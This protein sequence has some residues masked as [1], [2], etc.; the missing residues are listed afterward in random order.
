M[1][2]KREPV[3]G[4]GSQSNATDRFAKHQVYLDEEFEAPHPRTEFMK[5]ASRTVLAENKSPDIPFRYSINPYRGCEHGCIYCYARPSH[6]YLGFSAGLDF[7]TKILVK[8]EAPERLAEQFMAARWTPE[9]IMLSGNT[10]CYQ[11]AERRYQLT[12]RILETCLRF[13]NPISVITKNA[14]ITRDLDVL[15]GLA[16]FNC[17]HVTLS[18]TTLDE[19]LCAILEPRTSRPPAR[20]R[21]I[22]A[23]VAAG[24]PVAVNVAP[25]ILGLTDHE[26]PKI[27]EA[28]ARAG[29]ESA[30]YI[31]L[32]LPLAV[33]NLFEEW[34]ETHY[35]DRKD[36]ILNHIRDLRGGR[37]NDS[38]FGSRMRGRGAWAENLRQMFEVYSRKYGLDKKAFTRLETRHFCRP[39]DQL[40]LF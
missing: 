36:K 18:V 11:P 1:S 39:G 38:R 16:Q 29:A 15:S 12:R 22:E 20:L 27:L 17:V 35:P 37:L 19:D 34:L 31:P 5:D 4:R 14:L 26:L 24:V 8:E 28:A 13:R 23:L 30:A 21:A 2:L 40:A 7:E 25:L 9:P 10:D 33:A 6:E 32:R 3:R